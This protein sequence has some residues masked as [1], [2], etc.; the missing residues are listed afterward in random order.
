MIIALFVLFVVLPAFGIGPYIRRSGRQAWNNAVMVNLPP[1][2]VTIE[3]D[4]SPAGRKAQEVTDFAHRWL[5]AIV[6]AS[7]AAFMVDGMVGH[8]L[9]FFVAAVATLW[10]KAFG[11]HF[12]LVGHGVEI[13]VAEREGREGY[14]AAEIERMR[15]YSPAF[16][17]WTNERI[18]EALKRRAWLSRI[19]ARL[20]A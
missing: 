2:S 5:G 9:T 19:F 20:Y 3:Q 14:R 10:A 11:A 8:Y 12:D 15:L 6:I 17:G 13:I 7:P 1:D 4:N 18:D 16:K